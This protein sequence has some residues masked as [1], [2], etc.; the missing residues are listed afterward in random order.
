MEIQQQLKTNKLEIQNSI[1]QKITED[2]FRVELNLFK[3][4]T[5]KL[6]KAESKIMPAL[7]SKVA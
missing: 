1:D 2:D 5:R 3:A 7:Q 6:S 4:E